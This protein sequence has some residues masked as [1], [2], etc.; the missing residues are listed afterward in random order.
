[1][2]L[3]LFAHVETPAGYICSSLLLGFGM[4]G[5][6]ILPNQV[7]V[8]RWFHSRVGLVN[9]IVLA[10]TAFGAAMAPA[11]I[12]R[13]IEALDWRTAFMMMAGIATVPPLVVVLLIV[14]SRPEEMGLR[15]MAAAPPPRRRRPSPASPSP[16]RRAC[17]RSGSSPARSSSAACPA[18]PSTS[19]SS[20]S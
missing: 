7:L 20:S 1:M 10:A 9:G 13:L 18:T 14:R 15:P 3:Y 11:L 6:T 2:A 19:T 17:R 4:S 16:T 12:T 5:V 8:S